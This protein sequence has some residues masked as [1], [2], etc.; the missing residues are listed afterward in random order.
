[1]SSLDVQELAGDALAA[2]PRLLDAAAR[3]DGSRA[4]SEAGE[5]ALRHPR[6]GVQHLGVLLG[7]ELV[8]YAQVAA[9]GNGAGAGSVEGAV[10]P[11]HRLRGVGTV[12]AAEVAR[13]LPEEVLAWAHG[14]HPGA[15]AL[16]SRLRAERVRELWQMRRPLTADDAAGAEP[17]EGVRL[18]PFVVGQDE[19]A[20]LAVNAAAFADH[21]EQGRTTLADL[22]ERQQEAWFDP[23]GFL[24]AVQDHAADR[25]GT[26]P[27]AGGEQL[28]GFHWTKVHAATPDEAAAG[29]VYVLGVAPQAQGRR[30][31]GVLLR[32]GLAH[33]ADLP[34]SAGGS[35]AEV[36]LYVEADNAAAVALYRS[37]GFEVA[38]V[39]VRYRLGRD[40]PPPA[41][42]R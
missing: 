42:R 33:L 30:L 32:A 20:W 40:R 31:G 3:A 38:H 23:E 14:D 10:H 2:V 34:A 6:D 5:L 36:L 29:E 39:D 12:L 26:T 15:T 19:E 21:P 11:D 28:L 7:H 35:P 8:G 16:A 24:L 4:V 17:P 13:A 37:R 9:A 25:P 22:S 18:R 27:P 1:M 41:E